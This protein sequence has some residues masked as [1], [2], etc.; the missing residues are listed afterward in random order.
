VVI[1]LQRRAMPSTQRARDDDDAP[2]IEV[3]EVIE[4][5][6]KRGSH[7]RVRSARRKALELVEEDE[8]ERPTLAPAA[9]IDAESL[10]A[11]V[12]FESRAAVERR[13]SAATQQDLQATRKLDAVVI[14]SPRA[15][16]QLPLE[17]PIRVSL[18][19]SAID[20]AFERR[21]TIVR[22]IALLM[23]LAFVSAIAFVV[24]RR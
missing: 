4:V 15:E 9:P 21:R 17:E 2:V 5:D 22:T 14:D 12:L 23:M 3:I 16:L 1:L 11:R 18:D 8:H 7:T 13:L 19:T 10:E 6:D 24:F 20:A